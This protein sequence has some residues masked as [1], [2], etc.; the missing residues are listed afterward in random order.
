MQPQA[1]TTPADTLATRAETESR[2]AP[3]LL[4]VFLAIDRRPCLVVGGG[5]IAW[6]KTRSLLECGARVTMVAPRVQEP[7]TAVPDEARLRI[8]RRNFQPRDLEGQVLVIAATSS[9]VAQSQVQREA[10]KRGILCNVVDVPALCDFIFGARLRRGSLQAAITS[11]GRF[12]VFAQRLRDLWEDTLAPGAADAVE[13]LASARQRLRDQKRGFAEN[14]RAL[15]ELLD[16]EVFHLARKGDLD[17]LH[18]RIDQWISSY[19][20]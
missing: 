17:N 12:P 11:A 19:S 7:T 4:P 15:R 2:P 3:P 9:P 20:L 6:D 10:A 14:R 8:V 16:D 1:P 18:R 5:P 13:L